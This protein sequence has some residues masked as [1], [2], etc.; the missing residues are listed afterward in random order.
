[1]A[2]EL[3]WFA[4]DG[5]VSLAADVAGDLTGPTII[6]L[7][8]GGQTRHSWAGA[9]CTLLT[10]GYG[11]INLDLRGHGESTWSANGDYSLESRARD[12]IAVAA[13]VDGPLAL[14]GASM[15]GSTAIRA[16]AA[17]LAARALVLVDIVPRADEEG[18]ARIVAFMSAHPE[19]FLSV[20]EAALAVAAYNPLRPASKDNE[21]LRKNLRP[22]PDGRLYWHWDPKLLDLGHETERM[23]IEACLEGFGQ[24][25]AIPTLLVRGSRSDVVTNEG[26]AH[27]REFIPHLEILEA[28]GAGHMVAGDRNDP[29][30]D[31]VLAFLAKHLPPGGNQQS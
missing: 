1:M 24:V 20:D 14:I 28:A 7:H 19:G 8:G 30:N 29:F 21:G 12:L 23:A 9:M 11:V 10:G 25:D 4:G 15:G 18:V 13:E 2:A 26:V 17:G 22:G 5:G 31:A 27:L 3:R 16:V 6:L